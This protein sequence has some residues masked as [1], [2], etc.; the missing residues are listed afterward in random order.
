MGKPSEKGV[1]DEDADM[2]HYTGMNSSYYEGP[3]I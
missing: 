1:L 3:T 2:V